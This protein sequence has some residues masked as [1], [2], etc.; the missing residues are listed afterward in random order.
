MSG[1]LF[2][3]FFLPIFFAYTWRNPNI[4]LI[5]FQTPSQQE[6][7][8]TFFADTFQ[9]IQKLCHFSISYYDSSDYLD[10][11]LIIQIVS[12]YFGHPAAKPEKNFRFCKNIANTLVFLTHQIRNIK[13]MKVPPSV[14]EVMVCWGLTQRESDK[15]KMSVHYL[16]FSI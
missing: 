3:G 8:S 6:M 16:K 11:F 5:F 9:I 4:F 10:L 7:Q 15:I 14:Q 13:D 2:G 12:K 1:I